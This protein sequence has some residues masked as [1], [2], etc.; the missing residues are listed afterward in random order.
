MNYV[1]YC[2]CVLK[3]Y[4]IY[5]QIWKKIISRSFYKWLIKSIYSK[6]NI[7]SQK[8]LITPSQL[9]IDPLTMLV[10]LVSYML[11]SNNKEIII[12]TRT[13]SIQP[14]SLYYQTIVKNSF[15][16]IKP[17]SEKKQNMLI[18][19]NIFIQ[20]LYRFLFCSQFEVLAPPQY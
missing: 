11:F 9:Q 8:T 3:V 4:S 5:R 2:N 13:V 17:L 16:I 7:L 18:F 20:I 10:R 14:H 1:S 12:K 15:Y 6:S 19:K